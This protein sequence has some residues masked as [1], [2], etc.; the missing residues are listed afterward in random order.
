MDGIAWAASAMLAARERLEIASQNLA[1][2]STDGFRGL[3]ARGR[4]T[5]HGVRISQ[6]T[7]PAQGP[8]RRTGRAYDLALVGGGSFCLRD[9]RGTPVHTRDG[10]FTPD[11]Y[12]V[13][14]DDAGRALMGARG[15]VHVLPGASVDSRGRVRLHGRT[16]DRILLPARS[17]VRSG[18]LEA[19]NVDAVTQMIDVLG[20]QRAFESAEK[21]VAAIDGT[22]RKAADDVAKVG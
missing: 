10:A 15:E 19:A 3:V 1:N 21:A 6:G 12:G 20:A 8:L 4:L 14:R 11:R 7:L 5:A 22:Q 16:I 13:L 18:Y 17:S 2:A 9:A